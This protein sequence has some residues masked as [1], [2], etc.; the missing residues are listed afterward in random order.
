MEEGNDYWH[1][2]F[3]VDVE[4]GNECR[5]KFGWPRTTL[6]PNYLPRYTEVE[7]HHFSLYD[8]EFA[9]NLLNKGPYLNASY[10]SIAQTLG[11]PLTTVVLVS[12]YNLLA[13][14]LIGPFVAA[15]ATKFGKRPVFLFSTAICIIGTAI[16]EARIDYN[17]LLAARIVQGFA[18]SAFES[19]IV[20]SVGDL[21]FVHERGTRVAFINFILNACS[22]LASIICG[23]VFAGL[24]WLWL[25]HLF[26]IFLVVQFIA[27][28]LF[29]P[30][31]T[32]I[33][34][35]RPAIPMTRVHANFS[36]KSLTDDK[37]RLSHAAAPMSGW[38]DDDSV[39]NVP[40]PNVV[41]KKKTFVESMA[42]FTGVYSDDSTI[43]FLFGPFLS[44]ACPGAC[45]SILASGVLTAL[46]V[47][48]QIVLA[49]IFAAPPYLFGPSE[50]GFLGFGPFAGGLLAA[51]VMGLVNEPII[52]WMVRKN[53]GV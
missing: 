37:K 4:R 36:M 13:A 48:S 32:Y 53:S 9:N 2:D 15:F 24:G 1:S 18:T 50:V 43:K 44:L 21:Y 7:A 49:G 3:G 8:L 12:G 34:G 31:T 17:H 23:Q 10:E 11:L 27:M 25:F 22:G 46:Y 42:I 33:R 19:L 51:I 47:G 16:G 29:C 35:A 45:Y 40:A 38:Y 28:F 39:M 26:Q 14:G 20:S 41:P 5:W 6:V 52:Q 30:E